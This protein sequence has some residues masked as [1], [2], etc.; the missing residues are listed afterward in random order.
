MPLLI[1]L[2]ECLL[3]NKSKATVSLEE[4]VVSNVYSIEALV[5]LL[6]EKGLLTQE[7]ILIKIKEIQEKNK[8]TK[9]N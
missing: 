5:E 1:F 8:R 2:Y 9:A 6:I 3:M 4:L 7:E